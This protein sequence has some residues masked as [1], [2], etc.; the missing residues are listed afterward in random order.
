MIR[1]IILDIDGTLTDMDLKVDPEIIESLRYVQ[2][3]GISIDLCSGNVLPVMMG[4]RNI[5]GLKGYLAAEN[6]GIFYVNGSIRKDFT[7]EA[8]LAAFELI[9]KNFTVTE[10]VTNR[11]RETSIAF[12]CSGDIE[13]LKSFAKEFPV[14]IQY[15]KFAYHILNKNQDK[16]HA[17]NAII[18]MSSVMANEVLVCGDSE[19]DLPMYIDSVRKAAISNSD[20]RLK[21]RADYVSVDKF[22]KGLIEILRFHDLIK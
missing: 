17:V 22:G 12:N 5:L 19:N 21:E 6:G 8:P 2:K 20:N 4:I 16:G 18:Q 9:T 15:S 3:Q 1:K 11:W 10:P 13:A 7:N 14:S